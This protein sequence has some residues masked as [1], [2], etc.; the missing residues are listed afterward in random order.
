METGKEVP[1]LEDQLCL[2]ICL[3]AREIVRHYDRMLSELSLTCTQYL[4]MMYLWE[5]GRSNV[6][7]LSRCLKLDP[8]TLTPLLK[9]LEGKGL[10]TRARSA[11]DQRNLMLELTPAGDAL[12]E[13]ARCLPR[14]TGS[15][16][17]LTAAETAELSRLTRKA[18]EHLCAGK[19]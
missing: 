10:L 12:R 16:F 14:Q 1:R 3:C 8:S 5:R 17:G 6:R 11:E 4:V 9:K 15:C 2:P 19:P 13:K 7:D 18:L